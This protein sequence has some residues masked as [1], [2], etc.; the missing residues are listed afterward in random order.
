MGCNAW[1][2][3]PNC[4][5][6]FRGGHGF[7]GGGGR[8]RTYAFIAEPVSEGWSRKRGDGTVASYVNTNARCPVCDCPVI[9]YRSPY[10]GRVFFDPPL[11]PPWPKHPCTD[12]SR[13]KTQVSIRVGGNASLPARASRISVTRG[14]ATTRPSSVNDGWAPVSSHKICVRDGRL[15]L[16]GDWRDKFTELSLLGRAYFDQDGPVW[17][18]VRQNAPG[19]FDL[20]V[21]RSDAEET[22]PHGILAFEMRLLPLGVATL[23]RV[24]DNDADALADVGRFMLYDAEDLVSAITYLTRARDQGATNVSIDLAV[25]ALYIATPKPIA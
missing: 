24:A 10:D 13:W 12:S 16:T 4:P 5:C 9:F 15:Q 14:T 3:D 20:A 19:F 11:G 18:K 1:N 17:A 21:L 25:A 2:H 8:R 7:G 22:R 6:D 23:S